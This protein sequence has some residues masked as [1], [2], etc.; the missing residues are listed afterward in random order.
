MRASI[1]G[2]VAAVTCVALP[3]GAAV[4]EWPGAACSGTLQACIDGA[5]AGD[6]VRIVTEAPIDESIRINNRSLTLESRGAAALFAPDR[7]LEIYAESGNLDVRVRNLWLQ[8]DVLVRVGTANAAQ[9]QNVALEG[10][11]LRCASGCF[12]VFRN[13]F[14][15]STTNV[16]LSH[17]HID[18]ASPDAHAVFISD[19][20]TSAGGS[21]AILDSRITSP[22]LNTLIES[23][24][25]G[26]TVTLARNQ[27]LGTDPA[28]PV[29][30]EG[31]RIDG[32]GAGV[33]ARVSRNVIA[34]HRTGAV[35]SSV[36]GP[37][38]LR[39]VNNTILDARA[40][41][42]AIVRLAGD[43][44]GRFANN[45]IDSA[46][47]GL[48][49]GVGAGT[50]TYTANHNLYSRTP[51]PRCNGAP[52]GA[53]DLVAT[54][55]FADATGRP[56]FSSPVVNAGS[57]ADQPTVPILLVQV[58]DLDHDG[59]SGRVAGTVDIG[60]FEFS[61]DRSFEHG[62][63]AQNI[64]ANWTVIE[65]PPV[66][67]VASDRLQIAAY[68]RTLGPGS[69]LPPGAAK[70][71]GVWFDGSRHTIFNQNLSPFDAGRR[72]HVLLNLSTHDGFVHTASTG[73]ILFNTTRIDRAGLDDF[74]AAIP[75]VTQRFADAGSGQPEVYNNQPIGVWYDASVGRWKIF[76]QVAGG[77]PAPIP[78][79]A[80]F[81]VMVPTLLSLGAHA[82]RT[83]PLGVPVA[84]LFLDH[85]LLN[86]N[87]CAHAYITPTFNP[88]DVYVPSSVLVNWRPRPDGRGN[89]AISRGDGAQIPAG[90]AFHVY[91]DPQQSRRC[92]ET[93]VFSD[94]FEP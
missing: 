82:Y 12:R 93:S 8:D 18:Q 26:A 17:A 92:F 14:V 50:G 23:S 30:S 19:I 42:V 56:V 64:T 63:L 86:N 13:A 81:N 29:G 72:F 45:L 46:D 27:F 76:N 77:T 15:V 49:A 1:L 67:L 55:Q 75:I 51:T 7:T 10:L 40:S 11:R 61:L 47:C 44:N 52:G 78:V 31:L 36:A 94:G 28:Q 25:G 5:A 91:V 69:T 21:F 35:L 22:R 9:T 59:R 3:A 70:H 87:P 74:P 62:A 66:A 6:T 38:D 16:R 58:P 57:N 73:N 48:N 37:I 20:A 84:D 32:R 54:A 43:I 68:G 80:R 24:A 60:A 90:A 41:A 34:G 65:N 88:N 2:L 83:E 39:F 4:R 33:I 71:L 79:N 53:N 89:W 85:P